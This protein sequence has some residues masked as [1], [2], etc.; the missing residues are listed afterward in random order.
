MQDKQKVT[1]YLPPELHRKLK[2]QAAIDSDSMSDIARQALAFY[3]SHA[4]VVAEVE[5]G[6]VGQTHCVHSCPSC[7]TALVLKDKHLVQVG[8]R[9]VSQ[10]ETL[11]L[12]G[13]KLDSL[14]TAQV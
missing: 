3:L 8:H 9:S 6:Q 1:L 11:S 13:K 10:N 14:L 4:E 2:I 5:Q 7:Q 12:E